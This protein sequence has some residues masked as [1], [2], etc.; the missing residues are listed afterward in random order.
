VCR[1]RLILERVVVTLGEGNIQSTP[2]GSHLKPGGNLAQSGNFS[3]DTDKIGLGTL[4]Q[5]WTTSLFPKETLSPPVLSEDTGIFLRL[6]PRHSKWHLA[7][8]QEPTL[9][10]LFLFLFLVSEFGPPFETLLHK[11]NVNV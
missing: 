8:L 6:R 10:P 1:F 5:N 7:Y 4:R 11:V 9:H 3:E 2:V